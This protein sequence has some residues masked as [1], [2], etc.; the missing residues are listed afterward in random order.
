MQTLLPLYSAW[1]QLR[2]GQITCEE[3]LNIL[4]DEEGI[5]NLDQLD[6]EVSCR[7]FRGVTNRR[8]LP[9]VISLLLWRSCYYL[10]SPVSLSNEEIKKLSDRTLV[11][12]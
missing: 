11:S 8:D 7:F 3:A 5:V 6:P 1:Q 9:P 12:V 10:G 4:V 2:N